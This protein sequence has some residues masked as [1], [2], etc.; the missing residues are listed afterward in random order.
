[1][2][3]VNRADLESLEKDAKTVLIGQERKEALEALAE[4]KRSESE[5]EIKRKATSGVPTA[6]TFLFSAALFFAGALASWSI[7]WSGAHDGYFKIGRLNVR[8]IYQSSDPTGFALW[9]AIFI[10]LCIL[11]CVLGFWSLWSVWKR[12]RQ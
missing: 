5:I 11:C 12:C 3:R 7:Y 4:L 6:R 10:G 1:M 8:H 2:S 9:S